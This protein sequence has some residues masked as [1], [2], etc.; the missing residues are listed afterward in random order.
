MALQAHGA[1]L[2]L[3]PT[4][5][6]RDAPRGSARLHAEA[7]PWP[8]LDQG[9]GPAKPVPHLP[10][11]SHQQVTLVGSWWLNHCGKERAVAME[12]RCQTGRAAP[13]VKTW[14]ELV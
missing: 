7:L 8:S 11:I 12:T 3:D 5:V 14:C 2:V 13:S 6:P 1:K 9:W 10:F 4:A